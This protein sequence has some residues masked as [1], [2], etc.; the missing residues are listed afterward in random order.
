MQSPE[1]NLHV[2]KRLLG[3]ASI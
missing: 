2:V 1:R 3:H